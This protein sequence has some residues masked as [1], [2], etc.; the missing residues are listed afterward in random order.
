MSGKRLLRGIATL[1]EPIRLGK[2][3]CFALIILFGVS[4]GLAQFSSGV[5]GTLHDSSGAVVPG[6][7]VTVT[8]TRLNVT[9]TSITSDAGY[10]RIDSIAAS[11][12]TIQIVA[13]GFQTFQEKGLTLQVGEMRTL[14]PSLQPGSVTSEV[15]VTAEQA[16]LNLSAATT[17]SII[18]QE[19]IAVTPLGGQNVYGL[20]SLTP[21]ITGSGTN[22]PD[23]YTNEYAININAAGLRQELNGYQID[24]AYTDTPSRAGGTSI[25]PNPEIVESIDIR[26]NNFDAGKGRNGGATVDVFTKSGTNKFHGTGD[27]YFLNDNLVTRTEFQTSV[28]TFKRQEM[29]VTAGG[30]IIRDKLFFYGAI[31]VLRSSAVS[32]SAYTVETQD[33]YNYVTANMPNN[34]STQVLTAAKPLSFA[35]TNILTAGQVSGSYFPLPANLPASL[36]VLGTANISYSIPKNGYQYSV[37]GDNYLGTK[38]RIYAEFMR[39]DTTSVSAT[40]RPTLNYD[41]KSS[42]D[43]ANL[44]WTHTFSSR[45]LNEVGGSMIRPFGANLPVPTDAIPYINVTGLT[46]FANWGRATSPRPRS[47]GGMSSRPPSAGIRS[48]S[49]SSRTTSARQM[50]RAEP[51]TGRPTTSTASSTSSRTSLRPRAPRRSV[52]LPILKRPTIAAIARSSPAS[53]CRMIGKPRPV[54][55]SM[56]GCASIPW[57]TSSPYLPL[58]LRTSS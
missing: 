48:G 53:S 23:N 34:V 15:T 16:A 37:R 32:A 40:P 4:T 42:S 49:A 26:T 46:G 47:V 30:P 29:G 35:T 12:Y 52:F 10:F 6:A 2:S 27:Y 51:S 14:S 19:T 8:D 25:S 11:T 21:G 41:T 44:D 39:T 7:K 38:D 5:E 58:S 22:S 45:L 3:L 54:L 28:P 36:P 1:L 33:L 31:D 17:G 55:P 9:K 20:A 24:G 18:S 13:Q 43:F 50:H 57:R 56:P